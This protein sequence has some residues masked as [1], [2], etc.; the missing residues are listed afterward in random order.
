MSEYSGHETLPSGILRFPSKVEIN[1]SETDTLIK[2]ALDPKAGL[3]NT[4]IPDDNFQFA[5]HPD[6]KSFQV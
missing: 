3:F 2:I 5:S 4:D 6:A 1:F